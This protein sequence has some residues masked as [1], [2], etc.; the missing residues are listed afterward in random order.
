MTPRLLSCAKLG[1]AVGLAQVFL[2]CT[3]VH[4]E[5][6]DSPAAGGAGIASGGDAGS[7]S[8]GGAAGSAAGAS[9]VVGGAGGTGGMAGAAPGGNANSTGGSPVVETG[10]AAGAGGKKHG[11]PV[12]G[13]SGGTPDPGQAGA[14]GSPENLSLGEPCGSDA[15]C[16]PHPDGEVTCTAAFAGGAARCRLNR[17]VGEGEPCT[18]SS[19]EPATPLAINPAQTEFGVCLLSDGL[20]CVMFK[21]ARVALTG[22]ACSD[23]IPC[24]R[25]GEYCDGTCFV[26]SP[27]G[28]ACTQGAVDPCDGTAYCDGVRCVEGKAG[29]AACGSND[30]CKSEECKDGKCSGSLRRLPKLKLPGKPEPTN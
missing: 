22:D 27:L 19:E 8:S 3:V 17:P 9:A 13:G 28:A 6:R 10:G 15:E 26:R 5:N 23:D 4:E 11:F 21:C 18:R 16:A 7:Y 2:A 1:L 14:G 24:Y 30:E 12:N 20:A 25:S 29:G